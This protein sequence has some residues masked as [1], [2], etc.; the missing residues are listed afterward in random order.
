MRCMATYGNGRRIA[1]TRITRAPRQTAALGKT[2]ECEQRV[3]RGG[4]WGDVPW[5]LRS[6]D[7]GKND[8]GI[9]DPK[10]GFRIAR[11]LGP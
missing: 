8:S 1:G 11:T 9:R 4:S 7:R 6:A 2:G 3:L 10:I 5:L